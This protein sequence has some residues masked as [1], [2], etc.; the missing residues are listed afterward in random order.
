MRPCDIMAHFGP[1]LVAFTLS[2]NQKMWGVENGADG[3]CAGYGLGRR[4]GRHGEGTRVVRTTTG[5]GG[6]SREARRPSIAP[7]RDGARA[8][9]TRRGVG[10]G[11]RGYGT[12]QETGCSMGRAIGLKHGG[13]ELR[14]RGWGLAMKEFFMFQSTFF[15][16]YLFFIIDYVILCLGFKK[17]HFKINREKP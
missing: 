12:C 2:S 3:V 13:G 9:S 7:Y 5:C 16:L 8:W 14:R 10:V 6:A 4:G 11:A 17:I 15:F 1:E